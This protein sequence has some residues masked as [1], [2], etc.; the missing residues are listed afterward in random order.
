MQRVGL[1]GW[2][3]MVGSVLMGRMHAEGDFEHCEASFFSTSAAGQQAPVEAAN[4]KLL[5]AHDL[6]AL[7]S[8]DVI[9]TA[10]GS[11]FTAAVYQ[12]LRDSGCF[13]GIGD[14]PLHT[15]LVGAQRR[16]QVFDPL[17]NDRTRRVVGLNSGVLLEAVR[18]PRIWLVNRPG[19]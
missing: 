8:Q 12:P 11:D 14:D 2:R 5:D 4:S 10:Q 18:Q 19:F 6:K 9:V 15:R 3:G 1:V 16:F 13:V 7:A 17:E